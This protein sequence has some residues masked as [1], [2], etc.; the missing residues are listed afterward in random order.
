MR[1]S[2]SGPFK[3]ML[4]PRARASVKISV[5][6]ESLCPDSQ[7]FVFD[8]L[9]PTFEIFGPEELVVDLKPFGKANVSRNDILFLKE[10]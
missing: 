1:Y 5:Y 3:W 10:L 4:K 7:L 8:Q 9:A 2:D 6:Y